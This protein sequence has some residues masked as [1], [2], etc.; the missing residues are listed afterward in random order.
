M[1]N[2]E[3]NY[4]MLNII[5]PI[6]IFIFTFTFS[7]QIIFL[8]LQFGVQVNHL[9]DLMVELFQDIKFCVFFLNTLFTLIK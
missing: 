5:K 1:R 7:N 2:V 3:K 6:Y 9:L 8:R 4:K